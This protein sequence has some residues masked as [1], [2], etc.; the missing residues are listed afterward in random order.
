MRPSRKWPTRRR[1]MHKLCCGLLNSG[2]SIAVSFQARKFTHP[3][4][5]AMKQRWLIKP[6]RRANRRSLLNSIAQPRG[7]H[8]SDG[9]CHR[10]RLSS[11]HQAHRP[12][13]GASPMN[14]QPHPKISPEHLRLK[15]IVYLR[16]SSPKQVDQ[17]LESQRLQYA[18]A[19]RAKR[20]G[21]RQVETIDC[22]LGKSASLGAPDR[23]AS[24]TSSARSP[25]AKSVSFSVARSLDC[26]APTRIGVSCSKC[27][28]SSI[29]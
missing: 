3:W 23:T 22:D 26:R 18:M 8:H 28:R 20:L 9:D 12:I 29:R 6:L 11:A 25:R 27:V 19:D 16:Q 5:Q 13:Q 24:T 10:V 17:N 21:F 14:A 2:N 15:A 4:R 7:T 1:S